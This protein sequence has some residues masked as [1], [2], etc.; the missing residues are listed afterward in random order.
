[1]HRQDDGIGEIWE[2][3]VVPEGRRREVLK[4][5]QSFLMDGHFSIKKI[6]E[7]I[8]IPFT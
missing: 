5:A 6:R 3:I 2:R 8:N 7:T 4:V 1:M